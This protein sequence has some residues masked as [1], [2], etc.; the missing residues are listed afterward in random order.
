MATSTASPGP[1]YDE[2][3]A[4]IEHAISRIDLCKPEEKK[5][6]QADIVALREMSQKLIAGRVEIIIFG[7]ISTGKSALINALVGQHVAEVNVRGG[8]TTEIWNVP[9]DADGYHVQGLERSE[10]VLVDTPGLNEVGGDDRAKLSRT[11]AQ[12]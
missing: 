8:W 11:V 2:A 7:E 3:M 4:S 10:L 1:R 9:W 12:R 5:Q 6:L